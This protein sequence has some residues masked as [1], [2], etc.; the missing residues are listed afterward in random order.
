M[1]KTTLATTAALA[2]IVASSGRANAQDVR[3]ET[4][5][6]E[7]LMA[8]PATYEAFLREC[9]NNPGELGMTPN[10]INTLEAKKKIRT[11]QMR[12]ALGL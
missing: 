5:T 9:E 12:K 6:V 3:G 1:F 11:A 10:C 4:L 8:D 7:Q 2:F